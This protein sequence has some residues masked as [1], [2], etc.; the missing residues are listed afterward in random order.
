MVP[1]LGGLP[2]GKVM[3]G[4]QGDSGAWVPGSLCSDTSCWREPWMYEVLGTFPP[5]LGG[6]GPRR[7]PKDDPGILVRRMGHGDLRS[8]NS[9][10]P[11]VWRSPTTRAQPLSQ[12]DPAAG[13][14]CGLD[15]PPAPL[16]HLTSCKSAIEPHHPSA[17]CDLP[18][19][20]GYPAYRMQPSLCSHL[21]EVPCCR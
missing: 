11:R 9:I 20:D 6:I 14:G 2:N 8:D 3:A 1:H 4:R 5:A 7:L 12:W 21:Q 15:L 19:P 17:R 10:S 18:R 16:A 13:A